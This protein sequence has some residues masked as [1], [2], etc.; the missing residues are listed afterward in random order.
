M[1]RSWRRR[2]A[3]V[4]GGVA[5]WSWRRRDRAST[6]STS[7]AEPGRSR[8]S[9]RTGALGPQSPASMPTTRCSRARRKAADAG[10]ALDLRRAMAQELPFADATFDA[11]VTSLF[12]HHLRRDDKLAVGA[13]LARVMRPGARLVIADWGRPRDRLM[14]VAAQ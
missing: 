1:T 14:R 13:E 11:V 3:N 6:C 12:F 9:W 10:V 5:S 2:C 7:G 8:S 4:F